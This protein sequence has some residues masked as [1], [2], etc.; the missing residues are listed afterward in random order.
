VPIYEYQCDA[1]GHALEALQKI[2]DAPLKTCPEC[3]RDALRKKVS[4]A[5]FRLKGTGWY[6]TDFKK[7]QPSKQTA[8]TG[9]ADSGKTDSTKET[10][11]GDN[12][13]SKNKKTKS[14]TDTKA[15]AG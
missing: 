12:G 15:Q 7:K 2:S 13:G 10:A 14:G 11:S 8:D 6:E 3:N 1:C 9:A 4:A 5:A